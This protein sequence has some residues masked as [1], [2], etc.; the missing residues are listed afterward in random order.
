VKL[1]SFLWYRIRQLTDRR[2]LAVGEV[3]SGP[4]ALLYDHDFS[5]VQ[6]RRV[7]RFIALVAMLPVGCRSRFEGSISSALS[8]YP[9][10]PRWPPQNSDYPDFA[11]VEAAL[12]CGRYVGPAIPLVE[13]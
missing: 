7:V 11:R 1:L 12:P 6:E 4:D 9:L 13:N 3:A 5:A 8:R 10:E 2:A